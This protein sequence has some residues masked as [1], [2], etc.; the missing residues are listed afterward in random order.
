MVIIQFYT[1]IHHLKFK[2][3]FCIKALRKTLQNQFRLERKV[4]IMS[5]DKLPSEFSV[6]LFSNGSEKIYP[7]NKLNCFTQELANPLRFDLNSEYYVGLSE[8]FVDN[9]H[10]RK[11]RILTKDSIIFYNI[12]LSYANNIWKDRINSLQ[13]FIA[14][15]LSQTDYTVYNDD[16]FSEFLNPY[17]EYRCSHT[18]REQDWFTKAE[19]NERSPYVTS[20]FTGDVDFEIDFGLKKNDFLY[21]YKN[22]KID[23]QLKFSSFVQKKLK[24]KYKKGLPY[25]LKNILCDI[26]DKMILGLTPYTLNIHMHRN[27]DEILNDFDDQQIVWTDFKDVKDFGREIKEFRDTVESFIRHFIKYF[28]SSVKEYQKSCGYI[29]EPAFIKEITPSYLILYVDIVSE[30]IINNTKGRILAVVPVSHMEENFISVKNINYSPVICSEF[31]SIT[32][33]LTNEFGE[34]FP[35]EASYV[36]TYLSLRFKKIST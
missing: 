18:F 17:F 27:L 2:R 14:Y 24:I 13:F 22:E 35:L 4:K 5:E 12:N 25:T 11:D 9:I 28:I 23:P 21:K 30:S 1:S 10:K 32:C 36:P 29:E 6:H 3:K 8:L 26:I 19:D 20:A 15:C 7:N 34:P 33:V 16:Y 31:R